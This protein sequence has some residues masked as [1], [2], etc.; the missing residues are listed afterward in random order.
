[1][2]EEHLFEVAYNAH[3][4]AEHA[5]AVAMCESLQ[6]ASVEA[7]ACLCDPEWNWTARSWMSEGLI[8]HANE[9]LNEKLDA[10]VAS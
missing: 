1:M 10:M 6:G 8:D 3:E 4:R 9:V 2:T 5:A 7:L